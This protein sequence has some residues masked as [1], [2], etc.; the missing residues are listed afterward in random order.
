MRTST[1]FLPVQLKPS[2][3]QDTS[4][5]LRQP[6]RPGDEATFTTTRIRRSERCARSA[7]ADY[8]RRSY[9][10]GVDRPRKQPVPWEIYLKLAGPSRKKQQPK[11]LVN[12]P[13]ISCL[14]RM[15]EP[16]PYPDI[17]L[18]PCRLYLRSE[19]WQR[20]D[21]RCPGRLESQRGAPAGDASGSFK[22]IRQVQRRECAKSITKIYNWRQLARRASLHGYERLYSQHGRRMKS[23]AAH[24][25]GSTSDAEDR[26]AGNFHESAAKHCDVPRAIEF[27]DVDVSNPHQHVLRRAAKPDEKEGVTSEGTEESPMPEPRAPARILP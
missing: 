15:P 20:W 3:L 21:L 9:F 6:L 13:I 19:V 16:W 25:L 8:R 4:T 24:L 23:I 1:V 26:G 10:S 11:L 7:A 22:E 27:C 12:Q 14:G 18:F 2:I 5:P 17:S